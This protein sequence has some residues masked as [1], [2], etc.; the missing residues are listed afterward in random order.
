[1]LGVEADPCPPE[2]RISLTL[3]RADD[4]IDAEPLYERTPAARLP[5]SAGTLHHSI[6]IMRA[7]DRDHGA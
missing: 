4:R 3:Q 2:Q 1:M 7:A 6:I 5:E